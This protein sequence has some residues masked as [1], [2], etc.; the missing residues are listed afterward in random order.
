MKR[1]TIRHIIKLA[2]GKLITIEG[3]RCVEVDYRELRRLNTV[4]ALETAFKGMGFHLISDMND[5]VIYE[6]TV[7]RGAK[8][9]KNANPKP[10]TVPGCDQPRM[11]SKQGKTLTMCEA[12][13]KA[14][15]REHAPSRNGSRK[16]QSPA[17]APVL[18][19]PNSRCISASSRSAAPSAGS[20]SPTPPTSS[21]L[22]RTP[23][24]AAAARTRLRS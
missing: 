11:V 21:T 17:A 7:Q 20:S 18:P 10:C 15:W 19:P 2:E 13:Q 8:P 6:K 14:Y 9:M 3:E 24:S 12:H 5:E 23:V 4:T 1:P 22:R 16:R